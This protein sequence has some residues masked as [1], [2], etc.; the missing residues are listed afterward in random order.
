MAS[1]FGDL[2]LLP[3]L[4][5]VEPEDIELHTR[6]SEETELNIPLI[7]SPMDTVT[8]A[9]LAISLARQGGLGVIQRNLPVEDQVSE[10]RKVKRAESFIIRDVVTIAPDK[11]VGH[12]NRL[13]KENDISGL[14]VL[15]RDE[16]VGIITR[17]DVSFS[18][19]TKKVSEVMTRELVTAREDI[20]MDE[21]QRLMGQHKIE[22]LPIVDAEGKLKGLVTIKDLFLKEKFPNAV[23]DENGQLKVGAAV[24]PFDLKRAKKLDPL[25]D[26]LVIDVAH[27]H[28]ENVMKATEDILS[29]VSTEVAVGNIGTKE[30]ALDVASRLEDV[31]AVRAGVGSGSICNTSEVTK[32]GS[33]TLY[34]TAEAKEAFEEVGADISVIADG[35]ISTPGHAVLSFALGA[36]A[37]MMG[38]V[39]A[40]CSEAPGELVV[41]GNRYYKRYRGMGS[42]GAR[43]ERFA[44]DRYSRPSKGITEG[45]EGLVPYSG[46]VSELV[47][48]FIDGLKASLG[49]AGCEALSEVYTEARVARLSQAGVQELRPHN[50]IMPGEEGDGQ[51][52]Y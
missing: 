50:I 19:P 9:E 25:I 27:F 17:R 22:K 42:A 39:F 14:P 18:S 36:S 38:N 21:A 24:S 12:A 23:R 40:R 41:V 43:E 51:S 31:V 26:L 48:R 32:A 30:A 46:D 1:T 20:T 7:S 3:G 37:V 5:S 2:I 15:L 8:E 45:V 49:Y 33:P 29:E 28:N 52:A 10:V 44:L 6:L 16:L 11:T 35:G 34:A 13:M 47:E 4:S